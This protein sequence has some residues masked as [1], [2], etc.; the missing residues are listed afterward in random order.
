MITQGPER[1]WCGIARHRGELDALCDQR[2]RD[3]WLTVMSTEVLPV[4]RRPLR[5]VAAATIRWTPALDTDGSE[6]RP[7][8]C[9]VAFELPAGSLHLSSHWPRPSCWPS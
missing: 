4:A 9:V 6:K 3:H 2:P 5:P 8:H 7:S 1:S